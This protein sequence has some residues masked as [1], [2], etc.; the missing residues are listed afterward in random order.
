MKALIEK[1]DLMDKAE[2]SEYENRAKARINQ[3]Y[4]WHFI[5]DEY[6]RLWIG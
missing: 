2:L 4:S 1:A 3:A 5:G 6:E